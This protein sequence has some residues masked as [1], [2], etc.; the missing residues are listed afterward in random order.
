L[1][2]AIIQAREVIA[3]ERFTVTLPDDTFISLW[4]Y[5]KS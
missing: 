3:D 4:S 5:C 2:H 1:G